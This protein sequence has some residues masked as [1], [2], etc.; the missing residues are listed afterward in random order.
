M[1]L[2]VEHRFVFQI[3][4]KLGDNEHQKK[5]RLDPF[6]ACLVNQIDT[7]F[8]RVVETNNRAQARFPGGFTP[9]NRLFSSTPRQGHF[10][11][12]KIYDC[13]ST[14]YLHSCNIVA[15]SSVKSYYCLWAFDLLFHSC[16][17]SILF[18]F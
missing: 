9:L 4:I 13:G 12:L 8:E 3:T 10:G 14:E 16:L 17:F 15:L 6:I 7:T 18:T 11:C 1:W 2:C 5:Y